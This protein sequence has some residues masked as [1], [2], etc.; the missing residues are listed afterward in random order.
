M[1]KLINFYAKSAKIVF[2]FLAKHNV[3]TA[4]LCGIIF[5]THVILNLVYLNKAV[6]IT[7]IILKPWMAAINCFTIGIVCGFLPVY[8]ALRY[9]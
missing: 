2:T 8:T 6:P 9:K 5:A 7:G 3:M 4:V 1:K